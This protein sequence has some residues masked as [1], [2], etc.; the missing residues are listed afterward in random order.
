MVEVLYSGRVDGVK[1]SQLLTV[2]QQAEISEE[3][4][5]LAEQV[6][7]HVVSA[8]ERQNLLRFETYRAGIDIVAYTSGRVFQKNFELRWERQGDLFRV[9][10]LG[11]EH[12]KDI[13][14]RYDLK[15]NEKFWRLLE[16]KKLER[17]E[18]SYYLFG[19]RLEGSEQRERAG[20][21]FAELRIPRVL[22]YPV[23][24]S[25]QRVQLVVYEY[26]CLETGQIE[27]FR[28]QALQPAIEH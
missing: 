22:Y 25:P 5:L 9:V 26:V 23:Q 18:K 19:E 13:L 4:L 24:G 27:Y 14:Q 11:A 20:I 28:F 2:C 12:I 1:L 8:R 6:P 17:K 7:T 3:A 15:E 10:Y 16:D 21:E